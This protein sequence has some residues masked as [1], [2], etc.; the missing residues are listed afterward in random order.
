[1]C[2]FQIL[3]ILTQESLFEH[4]LPIWELK[5]SFHLDTLE[6]IIFK[7]ISYKRSP[8]S[9]AYPFHLWMKYEAQFYIW[10]QGSSQLNIIKY[11]VIHV[12]RLLIMLFKGSLSIISCLLVTLPLPHLQS[13]LLRSA[14]ELFHTIYYRCIVLPIHECFTTL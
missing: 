13:S 6:S 5:K 7:F 3:A 11:F 8:R 9:L 12:I 10:Y 14:P 2:R 1:M 4:V